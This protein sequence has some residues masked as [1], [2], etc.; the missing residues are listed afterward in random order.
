MEP[1]EEPSVAAVREVCEE[2]RADSLSCRCYCVSAQSGVLLTPER[3]HLMVTTASRLQC[4]DTT[5]FVPIFCRR[6]AVNSDGV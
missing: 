3:Q 6:R 2:V 5:G 1:E 4:C